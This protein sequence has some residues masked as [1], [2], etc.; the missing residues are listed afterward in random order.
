M[1]LSSRDVEKINRAPLKKPRLTGFFVSIARILMKFPPFKKRIA[2]SVGGLNGRIFRCWEREEYEEAARIAIH[3]LEKFRNRKSKVSP[4]LDHHH[5]WQFMKHGV[6]SAK[7]ISDE[8]LRSKLTDY[9][10]SGVEPFEGYDVAY[11]FLELS[12]WMYQAKKYDEAI[13]YAEISSRADATWAEPDFIL[14]WYGLLLSKV[15]AREHLAR[16]VE[17]DKRILFRIVNN[18]LCRQYP[19]IINELKAKYSDAA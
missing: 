14:G 17:K 4:F 10:N 5:W 3:A 15:D 18:D 7:H 2:E 9:A 19:H 11:S 8:E 6:D 12:R 16:A 1:S 13:Q